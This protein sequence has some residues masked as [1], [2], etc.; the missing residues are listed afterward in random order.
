MKTAPRAPENN[1][2]SQSMFYG[3][4]MQYTNTTAF[5]LKAYLQKC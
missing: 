4:S 5:K 3:V 1:H 2:L